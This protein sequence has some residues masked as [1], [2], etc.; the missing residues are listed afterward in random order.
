MP[1]PSL[2]LLSGARSTNVDDLAALFK[3]MTG[4]T[5]TAEE[6]EAARRDLAAA[7]DTQIPQAHFGSAG[8]PLPKG[9]IGDDDID[10]DD[11]ELAETPQDV[12]DMLGF[13]PLSED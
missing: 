12:I 3:Q 5:P 7:D 4:R 9:G 6:F 11:E 10:P 2:S 8:A 1:K 13:D